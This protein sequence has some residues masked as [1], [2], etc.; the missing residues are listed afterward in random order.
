MA[1]IY[2]TPVQEMLARTA[3]AE[4][5]TVVEAAD[6]ALNRRIAPIFEEVGVG[7]VIAQDDK[8]KLYI[9]VAD[10]KPKLDEVV[11]PS[12]DGGTE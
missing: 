1:R 11:E 3:V 6:A 8:S 4:R 12:E 2:L 7:G 10:D 9:S 5:E